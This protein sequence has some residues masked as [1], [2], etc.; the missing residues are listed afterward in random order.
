MKDSRNQK[1]PNIQISARISKRQR[2]LQAA[3]AIVLLQVN[4]AFAV[5]PVQAQATQQGNAAAAPEP[6]APTT[7]ASAPLTLAQQIT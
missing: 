4:L 1:I 3:L 7:A 6:P 2:R 5:E